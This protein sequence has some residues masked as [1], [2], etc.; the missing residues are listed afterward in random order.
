MEFDERDRTAVI[1]VV[2]GP[3]PRH[4]GAPDLVGIGE[5]SR[6]AQL[7]SLLLFGLECCPGTTADQFPFVLSQRGKDANG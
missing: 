6:R 7:M 1:L 4:L 5:I 3:I 2:A